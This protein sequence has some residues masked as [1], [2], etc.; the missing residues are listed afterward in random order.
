MYIYL[1][2]HFHSNEFHCAKQSICTLFK[3]P[4]G[5]C[6]ILK[7][8][9]LRRLLKKTS[10]PRKLCYFVAKPIF[11]G[12]DCYCTRLDTSIIKI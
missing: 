3:N 2:T 12:E 5:K 9:V 8:C 10:I 4:Y 1:K 7:S 11:R 6:D